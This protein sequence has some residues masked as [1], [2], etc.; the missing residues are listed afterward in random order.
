MRANLQQIKRDLKACK[1]TNI[2]KQEL[3]WDN[4]P[5]ASHTFPYRD[6]EYTFPIVADKKGFVIY[7][8]TFQGRIPEAQFLIQLDKQ[9]EYFAA[10]HLTI[11]VD[12]KHENQA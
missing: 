8:Y 9:L 4:P 10:S 5:A 6:Q 12:A 2:F 1:F 3:G 11:F 7:Q